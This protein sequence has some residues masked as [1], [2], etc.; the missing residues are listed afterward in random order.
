MMIIGVVGHKFSGKDTFADY[1]CLHNGFHKKAFASGLKKVCMAAFHL[2]EDEL[3][4]PKKKETT[5]DFW[6]KS[7]RELMQIVGTDLFR[8]H[9]DKEIWTKN[10]YLELKES[11]CE[12]IV[13]SDVR[14]ENE[15]QFLLDYGKKYGVP[16]F[17]VQIVRFE[18]GKNRDCHSSEDLSWAEKKMEVITNKESKEEFYQKIKGFMQKVSEDNPNSFETKES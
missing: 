12:N 11:R 7:P 16:V 18:T 14:F 6:G 3:N 8:N 15:M 4:D 5:N 1:I 9:F 17:L 10:M 2:R 13:V